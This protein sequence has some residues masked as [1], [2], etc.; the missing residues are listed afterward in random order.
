MKS[1][2]EQF[3]LKLIYR[4]Y[5]NYIDISITNSSIILFISIIFLI[6]STRLNNKIIHYKFNSS[7]V[8]NININKVKGWGEIIIEKIYILLEEMLKHLKK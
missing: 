2:L 8:G 7:S 5:N 6:L 4:I 3:K 1:P